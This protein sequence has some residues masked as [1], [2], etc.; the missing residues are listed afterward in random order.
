MFAGPDAPENL[1]AA[2]SLVQQDHRRLGELWQAMVLT[3]ETEDVSLFRDSVAALLSYARAHFRNE[4][5]VMR[6]ADYPAYADHKAEHD[7]LLSDAEDML[8]NLDVAFVPP[9]WPAVAAFFRH[10]LNKHART[11]DADLRAHLRDRIGGEESS[12]RVS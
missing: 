5:W 1:A 11:A 12:L 2:L 9:D 10:W 3:L 4:E 6:L 8:H 7:R